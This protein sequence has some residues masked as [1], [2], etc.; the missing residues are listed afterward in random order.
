MRLLKLAE[1]KRGICKK[2]GGK[3]EKKEKKREGRKRVQ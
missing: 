1:K 2:K 3:E